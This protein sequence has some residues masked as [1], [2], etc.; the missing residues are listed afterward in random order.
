M[1]NKKVNI[2]THISMA[3]NWQANRK[4]NRLINYSLL[5]I[6]SLDVQWDKSNYWQ[7]HKRWRASDNWMLKIMNIMWIY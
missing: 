4:A 1:R 6:E 3:I 5:I 2:P 7:W